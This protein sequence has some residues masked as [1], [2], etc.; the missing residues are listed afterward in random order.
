M[1]QSCHSLRVVTHSPDET[2]C[3]GRR[4]GAGL[5]PGDTLALTGDLGAGKTTLTRGIAEGLGV[6]GDVFSPTFTIIHEYRGAISLYHIDL[7]RVSGES[8]LADLG[9]EE[10][11][12]RGGVC[13][14]EWSEGLGT[15]TPPKRLEIVLEMVGDEDRRIEL[16]PYGDRFERLVEELK[17]AYSGDRD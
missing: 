9:L 1:T 13:V 2:I 8:D 10:Y 17:R 6:P 15:L 14:V 5:R 4:I 7:Y 3:L 12:A 16:I 11:F